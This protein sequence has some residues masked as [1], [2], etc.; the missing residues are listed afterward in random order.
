M[1]SK[2]LP[3]ELER[4]QNRR[5]IESD[6]FALEAESSGMVRRRDDQIILLQN[7][8]QKERLAQAQVAE[9][10]T[11]LERFEARILEKQGEIDL[12]R[13]KLRLL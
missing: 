12:L 7:L 6:L 8:R 3:E 11:E 10:E 2:P 5:R 13:K 1:T 4:R 9:A